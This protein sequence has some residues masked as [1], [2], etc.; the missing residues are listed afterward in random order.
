[1]LTCD[2]PARDSRL[3]SCYALRDSRPT[4][5]CVHQA[6]CRQGNL[7]TIVGGTFQSY[8]KRPVWGYITTLYTSLLRCP[9]FLWEERPQAMI[10]RFQL[11]INSPKFSFIDWLWIIFID[12]PLHWVLA[13]RRSLL[14]GAPSSAS[15]KVI[16]HQGQLPSPVPC[17]HYFLLSAPFLLC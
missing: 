11:R 12:T 5:C 8:V 6:L 15:L 4:T 2:H 3:A 13:Q 16:T 17:L 9:F 14:R 1:M 7:V 10:L